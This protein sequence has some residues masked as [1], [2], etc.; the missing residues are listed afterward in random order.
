MKVAVIIV[1]YN[2]EPWIDRC[3]G[4]LRNSSIPVSVWL[5]DNASSDRT[6]SLIQKNYPEVHLIQNA[7]NMGF[8]HANNQG[9]K[10]ALQEQYDYVFLLNQDAWVDENTI[11]TLVTLGDAH[12]EFG[13]ISPVHL[14]G[15]GDELDFGFAE[16]AHLKQKN[17]LT[18]DSYTEIN[19]VN[20]AFWMIPS[21]VLREV[22]GFSSLFFHYGEDVDFV[23]R[24]HYHGYKVVYAP[25]FAYHDRERRVVTKSMEYRAKTV[26]L[27]TAYANPN[28]T[29]GYCFV[30]AIGGGCEQI[31]NSVKQKD[32]KGCW[33]YLKYTCSLLVKTP[34]ILRVRKLVKQKSDT[35]IQ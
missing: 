21:K 28:H 17:E 1:S 12:P 6:V 10:K 24:L 23:N 5:V 29:F 7:S 13:I 2:F 27:M 33:V 19:F 32:W 9:I 25:V 26:Y 31:V 22:G 14:T 16:Y 20:A 30:K 15:K 8:G 35:F 34:R 4:S 11:E 3:L 18:G